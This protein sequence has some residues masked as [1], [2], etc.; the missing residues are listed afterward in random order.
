MKN[1]KQN[2]ID[3]ATDFIAL[4]IEAKK[5]MLLWVHLYWFLGPELQLVILPIIGRIFG[6]EFDVYYVAVLCHI[7]AFIFGAQITIKLVLVCITYV[8]G[9]HLKKAAQ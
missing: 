7:A 9:W 1:I 3:N 6:L 5:L 4:K 8:I 2:Y